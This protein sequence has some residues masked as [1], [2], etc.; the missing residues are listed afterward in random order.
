MFQLLKTF[1]SPCLCFSLFIARSTE[2]SC[3]VP[4]GVAWLR[5][6]A[7]LRHVS[8]PSPLWSAWTLLC[9]HAKHLDTMLKVRHSIKGVDF[10]KT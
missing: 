4:P 10:N 8:P 5:L 9:C 2:G 6:L 7:T 3:L 1:N